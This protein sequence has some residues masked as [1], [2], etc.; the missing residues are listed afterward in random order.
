M[1]TFL[2]GAVIIL[3]IA[4]GLW[5]GVWFMFVGGIVQMVEAIKATPIES[6]GVAI[7]I[8][9]ILGAS[10]VGWVTVAIGISSGSAILNKF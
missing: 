2:G 1:K 3:S 5:L 9:R 8:V 6:M 10:F 4:L 7:G